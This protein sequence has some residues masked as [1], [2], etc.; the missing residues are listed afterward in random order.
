MSNELFKSERQV[1]AVQRDEHGL[2]IHF[3]GMEP[4]TLKFSALSAAVKA[5]AMGY[6]MEVRLTRA[7]A[8]EASEKTGK[9]ATVKEKRDAVKRLVDHYASGTES[10]TMAAGVR[11]GWMN[12][13]NLAL[14]EALVLGFDLD[15]DTAKEKVKEMSP[16]QREAL[17][18]DEEVK[19]WLDE[20]YAKRVSEAKVD[21]KALLG[22]LK[23]KA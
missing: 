6:G 17:R 20:V 19:P 12:S 22:S 4:L 15:L 23:A 21:T 8:L 2:T 18:V 10:W 11:E 5:E 9:P 16:S 7:T 13:D 14:A 3:R 1:T